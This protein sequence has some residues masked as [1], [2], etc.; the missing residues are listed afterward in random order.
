MK[1]NL[2]IFFFALLLV[3]FHPPLGLSQQASTGTNDVIHWRYSRDLPPLMNVDGY[4]F[5]TL[6]V[7]PIPIS[8]SP[9]LSSI[10]TV[11]FDGD[12]NNDYF[13]LAANGSF[14]AVIYGNGSLS[15]SGFDV[16]TMTP[17]QGFLLT[18]ENA[19]FSVGSAGDFDHDGLED[20]IVGP[21]DISPLVG[22][23]V[24]GD[25]SRSFGSISSSSF[26]SIQGVVVLT[27]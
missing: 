23:L 4:I 1:L 5:E 22:F 13:L 24:F 10:G 2:W 12:G 26:P 25:S 20:F 9:A 11:D 18:T 19:C 17:S 21:D 16:A 6:P 27:S 7:T 15:G 3:I 8:G 14:V